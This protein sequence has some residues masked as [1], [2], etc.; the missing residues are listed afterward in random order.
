MTSPTGLRGRAS[1]VLGPTKTPTP[2]PQRTA[3]DADLGAGRC[4][5]GS[6]QP[7]RPQH[8]ARGLGQRES[9]AAGGRA[10]ARGTRPCTRDAGRARP[11]TPPSSVPLAASAAPCA[12]RCTGGDV[13]RRCTDAHHTARARHP[14]RGRAHKATPHARERGCAPTCA[15]RR[16]RPATERRDGRRAV[17]T[18]ARTAAPKSASAACY[19]R[20]VDRREDR[21]AHKGARPRARALHARDCER[22]PTA[23]GAPA[24]VC[25]RRQTPSP[26]LA[27]SLPQQRRAT[28]AHTCARGSGASTRARKSEARI[29]RIWRLLLRPSQRPNKPR[30][31]SAAH[32]H[33]RLFSQLRDRER[34]QKERPGSTPWRAQARS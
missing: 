10:R 29:T 18:R 24:A 31:A 11:T 4:T 26:P 25:R 22:Q 27:S 34:S 20:R 21:S 3:T 2:R 6:A 23:A 14:T 9:A 28:A 16:I 17:P 12:A 30:R 5:D 13:Q 8:A 7:R 32:D 1:C 33:P 15:R 19:W